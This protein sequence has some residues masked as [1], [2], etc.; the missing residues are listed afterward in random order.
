MSLAGHLT[1]T[2]R[3]S[4]VYTKVIKTR[5]R[6]AWELKKWRNMATLQSQ[7]KSISFDVFTFFFGWK[8]HGRSADGLVGHFFLHNF[9]FLEKF[10]KKNCQLWSKDSGGSSPPPDAYLFGDVYQRVD[11]LSLTADNSFKQKNWKKNS[12]MSFNSFKLKK[13]SWIHFNWITSKFLSNIL[14]N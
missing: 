5:F 3:F 9:L 8:Y 12:K 7:R 1:G 2:W 4:A 13:I 11:W 6:N 10:E 14:L